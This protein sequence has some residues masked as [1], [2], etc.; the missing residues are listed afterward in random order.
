VLMR[1]GLTL[2]VVEIFEEIEGFGH[3]CDLSR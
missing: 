2:R 3:G 1:H